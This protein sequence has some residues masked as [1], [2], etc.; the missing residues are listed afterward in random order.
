MQEIIE[1]GKILGAEKAIKS[2]Y[3]TNFMSANDIW[4]N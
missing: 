1:D 4:A 3:P 2:K